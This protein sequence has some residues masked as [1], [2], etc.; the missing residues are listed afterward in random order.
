ML[1][2][3]SA[4]RAIARRHL[5]RREAHAGAC[6][7]AGRQRRR[8]AGRRPGRDRA[9]APARC[10]DRSGPRHRDARRRG[11]RTSSR[12]APRRIGWCAPQPP[13]GS[14]SC[15]RRSCAASRP[16]RSPPA[17]RSRSRSTRSTP[18]WATTADLVGALPRERR[19]AGPTSFGRPTRRPYHPL[20]DRHGQRLARHAVDPPDHRH[21]LRAGGQ[22][23][24]GV[25]GRDASHRP[26]TRPILDGALAMAWTAIDAATDPD[27]RQKLLELAA[28]SRPRADGRTACAGSTA[29][30]GM[31]HELDSTHYP[32]TLARDSGRDEAR[33]IRHYCSRRGI[34]GQRTST[35]SAPT[36]R[37]AREL[38][39][40]RDASGARVTRLAGAQHQDVLV[41][42]VGHEAARVAVRP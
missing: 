18:T 13:R 26:P 22:P 8:R 24:A 23:P 34:T 20:L 2:P 7:R 40:G 14:T 11:A 35:R 6:A 25:R 33:R 37:S 28:R 42:D 39:P 32:S 3:D 41:D 10:A 30:S 17:R 16:A 9:A 5:H 29:A 36:L 1:E 21:R 15:A 38:R 31:C 12:R 27:L 4:R 19:G